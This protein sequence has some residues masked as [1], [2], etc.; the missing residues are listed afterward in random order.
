MACVSADPYIAWHLYFD[1][2]LSTFA[3]AVI[4]LISLQNEDLIS[5]LL[6]LLI[7]V[8]YTSEIFMITYLGNEVMLSNHRLSYSLFESN[9]ITQPQSTKKSILIFGE[10]LKRPHQLLIGKLYP[11]TLETFTRVGWICNWNVKDFVF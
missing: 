9:W 5:R 7:L 11:L 4:D 8:F 6:N 1:L 10:Y 3:F 2:I